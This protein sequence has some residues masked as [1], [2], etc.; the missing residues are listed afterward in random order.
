MEN[1]FVLEKSK[2]KNKKYSVKF[3]N[4]TGRIKTINFGQKDYEDFLQHKDLKRLEK[5]I[6]R[7]KDNGEDWN[8]PRK[9]AGFWSKH[10]LWNPNAYTIDEAI[11]QIEYS[12]DID[13]INRI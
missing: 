4:T 13:I 3:L 10:L 5:Y 7:H 6:L 2:N 8:N 11:R 1:I 12:F 9:S